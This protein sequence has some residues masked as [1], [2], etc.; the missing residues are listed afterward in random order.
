MVFVLILFV[1]EPLPTSRTGLRV[2]SYGNPCERIGILAAYV[3][4]AVKILLDAISFLTLAFTK[5]TRAIHDFAA[6][7]IMLQV[8]D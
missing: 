8:S 6:G 7:S 3:W 2:R 4:F 5:E 1:H